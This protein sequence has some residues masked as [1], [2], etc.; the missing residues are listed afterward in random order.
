MQA[1]ATAGGEQ[2]TLPERFLLDPQIVLCPGKVKHTFFLQGPEISLG[3]RALSI[4]CPVWGGVVGNAQPGIL[5]ELRH[6]WGHSPGDNGPG[7]GIHLGSQFEGLV[8]RG[9]LVVR[10]FLVGDRDVGF[11]WGEK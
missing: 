3:M 9:D 8:S 11:F 4:P 7:E 1:D 10:S 5:R 2:E 6:C